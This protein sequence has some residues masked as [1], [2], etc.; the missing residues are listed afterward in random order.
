MLKKAVRWA[1]VALFL[2]CAERE[3]LTF[4]EAPSDGDETG[5]AT[6]IDV[7]VAAETVIVS[8][9]LFVVSGLTADP[10]GVDTVY[11]DVS[12]LNL[13]FPPLRGDGADT[14]RFGVPFSTASIP[15]TTVDVRVFGVDELGNRGN[16]ASRR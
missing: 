9:D 16:T 1:L 11:I 10:D 2:G 5:P 12:G 4:P 15:G 6:R 3:R 14:V 13:A 7:P 8:G